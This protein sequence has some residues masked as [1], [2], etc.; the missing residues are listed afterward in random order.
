MTTRTLAIAALCLVFA[1]AHAQVAPPVPQNLVAQVTSTNGASLQWQTPDGPWSYRVYRSIDDTTHFQVIGTTNHRNFV[2]Y[3]LQMGRTYHYYVKSVIYQNN[4]IVESAPSN[5]ASVTLAPPPPRPKGVIAGLVSDDSTGLPIRGARI[6]FFRTLSPTNMAPSV[7]TDS[8]GQYRAVLDTGRYILRAEKYSNSPAV[9]GYMPEW[10]DNVHEPSL[11]TPVAVAE[12]SLS[13]ANFGL[14]RPVPPAFANITGSVTDTLGAPLAGASVAIMRTM[15]EMSTLEAITGQP[16]GLGDEI[17]NLEGVGHS[18]GVVWRGR[19]D[20]LG[21]YQARVIDGRSY[22]AMASKHRYLPEYY[23]NKTRPADADIIVVNG[24]ISGINFSLAPV[25]VFTNTVSGI[26]SDSLGTRVRSRIALLPLR[27]TPHPT[28][29]HHV[30]YGHTDSLGA[31]TL[32]AVPPGNYFVLAMPFNT[33]APAFYK[34][35]AFG[36][37]RWQDADTVAVAGD[38]TGIDIGVVQVAGHGLAQVRGTVRDS[39]GNTLQGVSVFAMSQ[40]RVVAFNVTDGNGFYAL[41]ALPSGSTVVLVDR[42]GFD[43]NQRNVEITPMTYTLDNINFVMSSPTV[44]SADEPATI[45][46]TYALDQ[47]YPNPFNPSTTISFSLPAASTVTISVVNLIG[48][49]VATLLN[50]QIEAGI[51]NITWNGNDRSGRTVA[52]GLYF[53]RMKASPLSGGK[54]FSSTRKMVL[55]K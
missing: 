9:P 39:Y 35:G 38:V 44:L 18:H 5:I 26:V 15:Q 10:Y 42:E 11:A 50:G 14:S 20:S 41:S 19:T 2:N 49:E 54:E 28:P 23:N 51:H 45:P 7:H 33:Y 46:V 53:Y 52:S 32:T 17:S 1:M 4:N 24:N 31:Y 16:V 48:Q 34:A 30:R 36:V 22:I 40:N 47:N 13:V 8:L 25:P 27:N 55:V 29:G 43:P 3:N 6:T 21:N 12:S 37:R